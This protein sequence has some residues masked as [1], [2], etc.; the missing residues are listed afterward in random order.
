MLQGLVNGIIAWFEKQAFGVCTWL[1]NKLGIKST[2]IRLYFIYLSFFTFGS[3]I[4]IYFI[5]A[6]LLENKKYL[7]PQKVSRKRTWDL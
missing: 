3:P 2:T 5:L 4:I 1:G 6:F 7:F